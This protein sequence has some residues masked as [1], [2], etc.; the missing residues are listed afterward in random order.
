M[1]ILTVRLKYEGKSFSIKEFLPDNYSI[2]K[3]NADF[4]TLISKIIEES[5]LD[6]IEKCVITAK[7]DL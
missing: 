7:F 4:I 5:K 3:E 1:I 2:C 6:G